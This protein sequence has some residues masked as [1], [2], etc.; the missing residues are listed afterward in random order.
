MFKRF[1]RTLSFV[2]I[3]ALLWN[4]LPVSV[5][6][7]D[8]RAAQDENNTVALVPDIMQETQQPEE[9]TIIGELTDRRTENI[10]EYLLSNGNTLAAVYGNPVHYQEDGQWRDID[11]TLIAKTNGTYVNTAG[12]WDVSFPQ[13]LSSTNHITITKDGYALSFGMAGQLRLGDAVIRAGENV[14][15]ATEAGNVLTLT[16]SAASVSQAQVQ[17]LD[18]TEA[19]ATA[20]HPQLVQEKLSSRLAYSQVYANTDIVYDLDSNRVKESIILSRY[21]NALRGYRYTLNTGGMIPILGDDGHI[22]FYDAQGTE[23][24]MT[25]PAPFLVDANS[26]YNWDI[27]VT[28]TG[29]NGTYTLTYLLPQSWLAAEERAWPVVLDPEV[30]AGSSATTSADQTVFSYGSEDYRWGYLLC[31]RDASDIEEVISR[32]YLK[33]TVL[34]ALTSADVVVDAEVALHCVENSLSPFYVGVHNVNGAWSSSEITWSNKPTYNTN[35]T[36]FVLLGNS[37]TYLW[38]VT[39]IVRQWYQ[40]N[41]NPNDNF[42][43]MFKASIA[44]ESRYSTNE[45]AMFYSSDSSISKP[46]LTIEYRNTSGL[47]NYWDYI[48]AS[49]GR[50]GTAY[51]NAFSGNLVFARNLM[52]F[53][54]NRMPVSIDLIYN[55]SDK[56][57]VS[58]GVDYGV[59]N[60]WRTNYHQRVYPFGTDYYVWEDADGTQHYF[61]RNTTDGIYYDED[62]L[63][64]KLSVSG[65]TKTITDLAGNTSTF[66]ASGRLIKLQNNQQTSSSINITYTASTGYL[67]SQITDGVGRVYAFSYTNGQLTRLSYKATGT[68]ELHYVILSYTSG[69]LTSI[70]DK[71]GESCSYEYADK[72]L[73]KATD[74]HG[75]GLTYTYQDAEPNRIAKVA[76]HQKI[77]ENG[78]VSYKYGNHIE[79]SYG[80]KWTMLTDK[81]GNTQYMLFNAY[82]NT[83]SVQDGN[84]SAVFAEYAT[85]AS[86][87][88]TKNQLTLSADL[89]GTTV[90]LLTNGNF[91]KGND[92][93]VFWEDDSYFMQL[94]LLGS[95]AFYI[96][97]TFESSAKVCFQDLVIAPGETYTLSGYFSLTCGSTQLVF[98]KSAIVYA[99]SPTLSISDGST[100]K[101]LSATYTNTT[102]SSI[103]V[104][105]TIF[106]DIDTMM[107]IDGVQLEKSAQTGMLNLLE[108]GDFTIAS[109]DTTNYEW[110]H[111]NL[112][113][114]D[115]RTTLS[116]SAAAVMD[117]NVMKITGSPTTQKRV[118]QQ[119]NVSG[120]Q[121]DVFAL[122]GW[123]KGYVPANGETH[124]GNRQ[125]G[126]KLT[127]HNTDGT[128][129]EK[130]L[131]FT[132]H[133]ESWQYIAGQVTAEKAYD[134]V[135]VTLLCDYNAN[136][137]YFDGIQLF[138]EGFGTAYTYN[139]N[140]DVE[141]ATNA[142]GQTTGYTY[143]ANRLLKQVTNYDGSTVAYTY[144]TYN[145][146]K[147]E[148]VT[149]PAANTTTQSTTH[150]TDYFYDAYG[151]PIRTS[152]VVRGPVNPDGATYETYATYT[153]NGNYLN[154]ATDEKGNTTLY[155]YNVDTG[156]LNSVKD[157]ANTYTYYQ[158]DALGRTE[159]VAQGLGANAP[160][161]TY[162]YDGDYLNDAVTGSTTYTFGYGDF[163]AA[164]TAKAGSYTLASYTYDSDR[165]LRELSYGNGAKI[166]YTYDT[167]G[168]VITEQ[169]KNGAET[170][171]VAYTYDEIG[172]V[173]RV[174]DGSSNRITTYSYDPQNR[175]VDVKVTENGSQLHTLHYA[176]NEEGQIKS[177]KVKVGISMQAAT[178]TA[179]LYDTQHRI[180]TVVSAGFL[181][182]TQYNDLG[183]PS[184]IYMRYGNDHVVTQQYTYSSTTELSQLAISYGTTEKTYAYAYDSRGNITQITLSGTQII[185]YTYDASNQ[186][187]REDNQTAGYSWVMTYDNAGNMLTRKKYSYTT[188]TLGSVLSTQTFT[189]GNTTW[190]DLL[191]GINGTAVTS[192]AIGNILSDGTSTYTW[193]NGR[194]LATSTKNGVTWTYTYDTNGMRTARTNG[195]T[196]YTYT[197]DGTTLAQMTVGSNTLIFA[198]GS[199]GFPMGVRYNGTEYNYVTNAFGDV[200]A[201]ADNSG[202]ELVAYHYDAW[203][204]ILS[205]GGTMASTLGKYNPLRY[206]SYVYDDETKLYYLQSRY[207]NPEICRFISADS[208]SYLGAD[209]TP[210]SYNL[211][212]YCGNNPINYTDPKGTLAIEATFVVNVL[213]SFFAAI[214]SILA[215]KPIVDSIS[216]TEEKSYTVYTLSDPNTGQVMYV[217]RTSNFYIRMKAHQLNVY[218]KDLTPKKLYENLS[219]YEARAA[220]QAYILEYMT[221]NKENKANNQ[222]NGVNP[223]RKDYPIILQK[224]FGVD[225][226]LD[227]ILTNILLDI[228]GA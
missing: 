204:N 40:V 119:V 18:L 94:G 147:K 26:E 64:L 110:T 9:I 61:R 138:N 41:D 223:N 205:T 60:G 199:N 228:F 12:V 219:Y 78:V 168:R 131:L 29:S 180:D 55:A 76:E 125:F 72:L 112:T 216:K 89:Q 226:A 198:Y 17:Q 221:L 126:I 113:F 164:K 108:N 155:S 211:F 121:G 160:S 77:V 36:D 162:N 178:E 192:D 212:T 200:I 90:D 7:A 176:Y 44:E 210:A 13:T 135:E 169:Y 114:S 185:K 57:N 193:K 149:Y 146:L 97:T 71:D 177:R 215:A 75:V 225:E 95:R 201:I 84:G 35:A 179:Y 144:D 194:Q 31:G 69:N 189:Y 32:F 88:A 153:S 19:K 182:H 100:W 224:G 123:G 59:G 93:T 217:G 109:S 70:L 173:I 167:K 165:N 91:E 3:I 16:V 157:P 80:N 107:K 184:Q 62:N 120:S 2:L 86:E 4:M 25:M 132:P 1:I 92:F 46:Q 83:I 66:D 196:A 218:R 129:T 186:L 150:S 68:S 128:I 181:Q 5:L 20:K 42:G 28:L 124:Y 171:T 47:E 115:G 209:G 6:G 163:G 101:R 67:I 220:E 213:I 116:P 15:Y 30:Q 56:D 11:N 159:N 103:T 207:Y 191:T 148:T 52:G 105:P 51:T 141:T 154:S 130:N 37:G 145:N 208:I 136:T 23:I 10:K 14:L 48:S 73:T 117:D 85:D 96:Q 21:D 206:R 39:D 43:M 174:D 102:N 203:G 156:V 137:V 222:I 139:D 53:D 161:V 202:N 87:T 195:S 22:D 104:T 33:F 111:S 183:L 63:N 227:S 45:Y 81:Q 127:I 140:G 172:R 8:L 187:V 24:V 133:L 38:N 106:I 142:K 65:S 134:Y 166:T 118:T 50:A 79:F 74:P 58:N 49:A 143:Y 197:Y 170:V 214:T 34:P 152:T 175:V 151:N 82:G 188:G 99:E 158:Y 98:M 54:G 190:G 27:D 122:A